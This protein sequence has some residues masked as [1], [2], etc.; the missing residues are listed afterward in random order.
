MKHIKLFEQFEDEDFWWEEE[1]PFD[2]LS[3][4]KVANYL[5]V[6]FLFDRFSDDGRA[7]LFDDYLTGLD[8]DDI[9]FIPPEKMNP[10]SMIRLYKYGIPMIGRRYS[11]IPFKSI[12]KEIKDRII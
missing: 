3:T 5:G 9:R 6:H 2:N 11:E 8:K 12:P 7:I 4:L 1:S 10:E